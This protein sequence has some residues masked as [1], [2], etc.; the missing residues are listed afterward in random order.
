MQ[1][2]IK[3]TMTG[4]VMDKFT[5]HGLHGI[6]P[7]SVVAFYSIREVNNYLIMMLLLGPYFLLDDFIL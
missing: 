3:P 2:I 4:H 6:G 1:A 5:C 7:S